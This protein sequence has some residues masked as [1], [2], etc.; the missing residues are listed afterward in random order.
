M[1][2]H[3]KSTLYNYKVTYDRWLQFVDKKNITIVT[4]QL[5]DFLEY[6][7]DLFNRGCQSK[8]IKQH[9]SCLAVFFEASPPNK[10]HH[11]FVNRLFQSFY[12]LRPPIPTPTVSWDPSSVLPVLEAW[13]PSSSLSIPRLGAK[14]AILIAF[15]T[16]CRLV[17]LRSLHL[18]HIKKTSTEYWDFTITTVVKTANINRVVGN[19][20][21]LRVY[22][23]TYNSNMCPLQA[24]L[25]YELMTSGFRKSRYLFVSSRPPYLQI[26]QCRLRNWLKDLLA[27]AGII[28]YEG[29]RVQSNRSV[30]SSTL[31]N[32]GVPMDRIIGAGRWASGRAFFNHYYRRSQ[33]MDW[34]TFLNNRVMIK[35]SVK[36][37]PQLSIKEDS[38]LNN[39]YKET[40]QPVKDDSAPFPVNPFR[41]E[42]PDSDNVVTTPYIDSVVELP[43]STKEDQNLEVTPPSQELVVDDQESPSPILDIQNE[44]ESPERI[45]EISLH[46]EPEEETVTPVE[47]DTVQ[48]SKVQILKRELKNITKKK[49][50]RKR[51]VPAIKK[52]KKPKI[53]ARHPF[54]IKPGLQFYCLKQYP[55]P[56]KLGELAPLVMETC[57][58]S[59]SVYLQNLECINVPVVN[60]VNIL[61][62]GPPKFGGFS[63]PNFDLMIDL[64]C[65]QNVFFNDHNYS[66]VSSGIPFAHLLPKWFIHFL[67]FMRQVVPIPSAK[68]VKMVS[69]SIICFHMIPIALLRFLLLA[70]AQK[71]LE[72][73]FFSQDRVQLVFY[74]VENN[75]H[76]NFI[77]K[78][79]NFHSCL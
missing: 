15:S 65:S 63:F 24:V 49:T 58:A 40:D 71:Q 25:D 33:N 59:S 74:P 73:I 45:V 43:S 47:V 76:R 7:I 37:K 22:A 67:P 68:I 39:F 13:G 2:G 19:L 57:K 4:A 27:E 69:P 60:T 38:I 31:F 46:E 17:E 5:T 6:F 61:Y 12:N 53:T 51:Q 16:G 30:V 11:P 36:V 41:I 29:T 54:F 62:C 10:L 9:R 14:T 72:T 50:T 3:R 77:H 79:N 66:V 21:T 35:R 44:V 32:N 55:P 52:P 48:L 20:Q 18:D 64:P 42:R 78:F 70:N 26:T 8:Y 1:S 23:N 34:G 56:P 28:P 75:E